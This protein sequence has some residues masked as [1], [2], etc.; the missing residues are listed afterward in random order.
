MNN[1][2]LSLLDRLSSK[3]DRKR[4]R[5]AVR[6]RS[7]LSYETLENRNLLT[8]INWTS[9]DILGDS[10]VSTNG[11]LVFAINGT[12]TTGSTTT[13][14]G[15]SFVQS[16]LVNAES[17]SQAQSP[18]TESLTTTI[19]N[20]N[21][22]AF[23]TG[24][25]G[26]IGQI[27][28]SGW[29]GTNTGNTATATLA[30][31]TIGDSYEVQ[32]F[33]NDAR[34]SRNDGFIT[35][36]GD[37]AGGFGVDLELNNQ[38]NGDLAGDYGI[39]TFIADATTQS[40]E[41]TG[42]LNG[43]GNGGRVQ[44]NAIQ[45]RNVEPVALLPGA[46]PLINEFSASNADIIDDDNGNSSDWIEIYNAGEDA[47]N[48]AGYRL[49]DDPTDTA[50][51][52]FP[53]TTLAGGQ[54]LVVFAGDD[55]DP[56]TGSDLYTE[57]G[58]S[59]A[60]EYLGFYDD[61]GNLISEFG[62]NGTDYPAQ[63]TDITYGLIADSNF[64]TS[65][66]FATPTPGS[67]NINPVDGV[68]NQLATVSIA[69]G[70]YET[71]FDVDIASQVPG[72]SVAYTTDG[73]EP[74]LTNGT[75]ID[76]VDANSTVAFT[77]NISETT[78]L[79]TS[80]V[81]DGFVTLATTTHT[82]VFAD[83]VISSDVMDTTITSQYTDQFLKD[84]LLDIPTLSFNYET[85]IMDSDQPEQRASI[86]WLAP[87]GSAGFQINAGISGFG[88]NHPSSQGFEKENYRVEFRNQY[89]GRLEFPLFEGFDNGVVA[90]DSFESVE[91]RGGS[92]DRILRGFGLSN[93][94]V[95]DTLLELGHAVPHGRFVHIISN[96]EYFGQ[97]HMRERW[98]ADF[99]AQYYGGQED[100][101]EAING[102][103]NNG[104]GT[105]NGWDPG[106]PYDG[107]GAAWAVIQ[108][109]A[110]T[111]GS[112][113][114][115]G[116]YQELKEVVNLPQYLDYILLYMA[117]NTENEY[118]GGGSVDGSVPYT[119]YLN[120]ADG[121]IRSVGDRTGNAGPGNILGTLVDEGDPEF[122]ALYADRIQNLF[123]EGGV[124]SAERSVERLQARIDET[125]M[126]FILESARY[127]SPDNETR[128][129]ES[130][131]AAANDAI[132]NILP[133]I[134]GNMI[135]NLR[136][137]G[138]FP[139]FDAPDFLID[140]QFQDGGEIESGDVLTLNATETIYYT[141]DGT[142]PRL[143]GGGI[144]DNAIAYDASVSMTTVFA[145]G[146]D[147]KYLD[148]GTNQGTVWQSPSFDDSSWAEDASELGYGDNP[149]TTI[150]FGGNPDNKH[151]TT[152]FRKTFEV[153]ESFDTATLDIFY[154]DGAV[155]YLNGQE[156]GRP[157]MSGNIGDPVSWLMT[158][159]PAVGDG[160]SAVLDITDDL[161]LG[162]NTL[163]IEVHQSAVDSSDLSFN[164]GLVTSSLISEAASIPLTTS[165]NVQA[166][167][168]TNGE[169]SAIRNATFVIPASQSDLRITEFNYHPA[170]STPGLDDG[171]DFEFIELYNPNVGSS[172]NLNGAQITGGLTFSFGNYDL[173][174]GERVVVVEDIAAFT[175]RYGDIATIL[176][177]WT[178]GLS[179]SGENITL[180]DSSMDVVMSVDYEDSS[181][182]HAATDGEGFSL[183]L[184]DPI[185]TPVLELGEHD[186]W[187][188]STE[189]GGTP[190]SDPASPSG[191]VVNE[192]LAHTDT[193][194]LDAI[195]LFNPTS[196]PVDVGGWYLSDASSD[197]LKFPIPGGTV[198]AA[199]GYLVF[200]ES[201]FNPNPSSP[202][203][204]DFALNSEGDQVYLTRAMTGVFE[205]LEDMV[206]FGPTLNG[207][208]LGRLP[209]GS[210]PLTSLDSNSFG[211]TNAQ[212]DFD[213]DGS[214]DGSDL[215]LWQA[216][217]GNTNANLTDGD[218]NGDRAVN[219][220]DFL[221]WQR[222]VVVASSISAFVAT[223]SSNGTSTNE[224][225]LQQQ[226]SLQS[227]QASDVQVSDVES[228]SE[229]LI[230]LAIA[231]AA[232]SET[233]EDVVFP[234]EQ[235][236][237]LET[238][239]F[240]TPDRHTPTSNSKT[241]EIASIS[242]ESDNAS[243]ERQWLTEELLE[244]V[245]G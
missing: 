226:E 222:Q 134:P 49:T 110:D 60:G 146:S 188:A 82:Y 161:V 69:R 148:N 46:V 88:G 209:N 235:L 234:T 211:S 144:N 138:L 115:T 183:V 132:E 29:W 23:E 6:R 241:D 227:L 219:G 200:D 103:V 240:A 74:S 81:R 1:P 174:P 166:R 196:A 68:I 204:N 140:G 56:A 63:F 156:I 58:L 149:A 159:G 228:S 41:L 120:D 212:A 164:A 54:Y 61:S 42:F 131:T 99:L 119:F 9:G 26:S 30:G 8:T 52:V 18:G 190:G 125:A 195:E 180:L 176:G 102:N 66:F 14:N 78:P 127:V 87:D 96:G 233:N 221:A 220:T 216:G 5:P 24:G 122:L 104:N 205:G 95:D 213:S 124:L 93:R 232:F 185:N 215:A 189:L 169:W 36:L 163:A 40:F 142:D 21:S 100:D 53:S 145:Y 10:D 50:K 187:R 152:Y 172:I 4:L 105:P 141:T 198:I 107:S 136:A 118:R 128:T 109:L 59:S 160:T 89:E 126:S 171:D 90:T 28:Q 182:W 155:V 223:E 57:F 92:H 224:P 75:L 178:G 192:I 151:I 65:S 79:R 83:D 113:N 218:A 117:G 193:P 116:G 203:A 135:S 72:G 71:A 25:L 158:A 31:L 62:P 32:I 199:G 225:T 97:F 20:D 184:R 67:P 85:V 165:T 202:G 55:D 237:T 48:L 44:I 15:V 162:T 245:F 177:E 111:D 239:N 168:F 201:D 197:L 206:D 154:D 12:T 43:V 175:T 94:F 173:L 98:D 101:Y 153:T 33:A 76:P 84:A 70:F 121:W 244:K 208:S 112:G 236:L 194:Q 7:K 143:E 13:V 39:G 242:N 123:G 19:A 16:S 27:I 17:Q 34:S 37:G 114:P 108:A 139:S 91:F 45:L 35:R 130:F 181:P 230:D 191:V 73:S 129:P 106:D 3:S 207:E 179:N 80:I 11:T 133:A 38:P 137:R 22:S 229:G 167:A 86:E 77:L 217:Y 238:V 157:N 243:T 147:W 2:L 51:Y 186:S 210:G 170:D 231:A 214:V 47:V 150:S 64:D